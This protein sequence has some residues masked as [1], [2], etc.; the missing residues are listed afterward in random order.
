MHTTTDAKTLADALATLKRYA[1]NGNGNLRAAAVAELRVPDDGNALIVRRF[2]MRTNTDATASI[3]ADRTTAGTVHVNADAL[4]AAI[5]GAS[6]PVTVAIDGERVTVRTDGGSAS[7]PVFDAADFPTAPTFNYGTLATVAASELDAFR[8]V[9]RAAGNGDARAVLASVY[10]DSKYAQAVATDTYRM[11]G[12]T[13][14]DVRG[15]AIIPSDVLAIAAAGTKGAITIEATDDGGRFAV[16]Y[17]R[18][19]RSGRA[20]P[21]AVY[22]RV[23]GFAVEGPYPNYASL[24]P[25]ADAAVAVWSVTDAAGTADVLAAFANKQNVPAVLAAAGSA[26]TVTAS[27]PDG[28]RNALAP[29]VAGGEPIEAAFNPKYAAEAIAHSGDGTTV[30]LRDGLKA[31][32][33]TNGDRY[34]LLMPMRVA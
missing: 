16:H 27:F 1:G 2:A 18:V 4:A 22:V 34:A 15:T 5:K 31:A 10:F 20:M 9:L 25:D 7:L 19:T 23:Q 24:I 33:F 21:R 3:A 30:R 17:L 6:G 26:V 28:T 11:H 8:G 12:A 29:I 32:H 13:L 14:A